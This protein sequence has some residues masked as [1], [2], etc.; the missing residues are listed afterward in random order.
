MMLIDLA[1]RGAGVL[2]FLRQKMTPERAR[3]DVRER[4]RARDARFLEMAR[5]LIFANPRSP[6]LPLLHAAGV[7]AAALETLVRERGLEGALRELMESGV[8][9]TL[10]EYKCRT[11]IRRGP[12]TVTPAEKDFDAPHGGGGI[13][14]STSGSRSAGT[15]VMFDWPLIA[16]HA[17]SELLLLESHGV[18]DAPVI[19]WLPA[20]PGIAGIHGVLMRALMRKPTERWFAQIAPGAAPTT[21]MGSRPVRLATRILVLAAR[22]VARPVAMPEPAPAADAT[23]VARA[24]AQIA[25]ER[26]PMVRAYPSGAVRI[27]RAALEDDLDLGG[28][29]FLTGG[30]ALTDA[31]SAFVESAGGK[32]YPRYSAADAGLIAAACPFRETTDDMHVYS[33]RFAVLTE[34]EGERG[35]LFLT[36]I[37][38]NT[39]RVLLNVDI[40]DVGVLREAPCS[41]ALGEVG[42]STRI[43]EVRS[44]T[45]VT[46]EGTAILLS[47]VEDVVGELVMEHGGSPL[48]YQISEVLEG[49]TAHVKIVLD[50]A[51]K[52]DDGTF[53]PEVLARLARRVRGGGVAGALWEQGGT[54]RLVRGVPQMTRAA[55]LHPV[56]RA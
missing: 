20:P 46:A 7:S 40:G 22:S 24:I 52:V 12:L 3:Q 27:A 19:M 28:A 4:L 38:P 54:F 55:K 23:R 17:A 15:S 48:D 31:R 6:Y 21:A 33:D 56:I 30:E 37:S 41:C 11:A 13:E 32:A 26:R 10:P 29:V 43:W 34:R 14:A 42:L 49:A 36:T 53:V 35:T 50:P 18:A 2:G 1:R 39:G 45:K 5:A 47:D 44:L 9:V 8:H 25:A 51:V 16:E